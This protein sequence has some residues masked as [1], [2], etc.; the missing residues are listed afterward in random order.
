MK[1]LL[2]FSKNWR[3]RATS[4]PQLLEA[5]QEGTIYDDDNRQSQLIVLMGIGRG[6]T[7]TARNTDITLKKISQGA[8]L[9]KVIM[10]I[11]F[12]KGGLLCPGWWGK[13]WPLYQ[14]VYSN[15]YEIEENIGIKEQKSWN[16]INALLTT[17]SAE[18]LKD[19]SWSNNPGEMHFSSVLLH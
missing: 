9:L 8:N 3:S 5:L 18:Q 13:S 1:N 10:P 7:Q 4:Q 12:K 19:F 2:R 6:D 17:D 16:W 11:Y 15:M 14:D